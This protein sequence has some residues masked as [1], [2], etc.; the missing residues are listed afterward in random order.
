MDLGFRS[1]P[2]GSTL[3]MEAAR[4]E[5]DFYYLSGGELL[6]SCS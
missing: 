5:A 3:T 2:Y 6:V 4:L 1:R